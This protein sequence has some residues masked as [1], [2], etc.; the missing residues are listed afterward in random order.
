[1][2]SKVMRG[3][4][5]PKSDAFDSNPGNAWRDKKREKSGEM[6]RQLMR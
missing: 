1:M 6:M 2:K 3:R 5:M 4:G